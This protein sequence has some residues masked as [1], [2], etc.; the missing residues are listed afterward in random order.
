MF[1]FRV[2]LNYCQRLV[3]DFVRDCGL[4]N[5]QVTNKFDAGDNVRKPLKP[6]WIIHI[7]STFYFT[8]RSK[9]LWLLQLNYQRHL[10]Q[11]S[12]SHLV[13]FQASFES[14]NSLFVQKSYSRNLALQYQLFL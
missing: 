5:Y 13:L 10:F 4:Q 14:R 11:H 7:V 12:R 6:L 2:L 8:F 3:Y 9:F 1:Y